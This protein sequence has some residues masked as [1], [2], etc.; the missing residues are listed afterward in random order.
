MLQAGKEINQQLGKENI[1]GTSGKKRE[2]WEESEIWQIHQQDTGK[3]DVQYGGQVMSNVENT[4]QYIN[5]SI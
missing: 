2:F 5:G 4:D 1:G 3:S